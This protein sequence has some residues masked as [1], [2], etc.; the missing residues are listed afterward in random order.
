MLIQYIQM[1]WKSKISQ[2]S[3]SALY[4]DMFLKLDSNGKITTQLYEEHDDFNFS[5]VS[6]FLTYVVIFQL[7]LYLVYIYRSLFD[8]QVNCILFNVMKINQATLY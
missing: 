4:L 1:N 2:S 3:T 8:M 5:L 6:T 7:H